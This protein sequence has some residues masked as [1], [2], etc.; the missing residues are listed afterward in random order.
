MPGALGTALAT[1]TVKAQVEASVGIHLHVCH[2]L[3]AEALHKV[4][5]DPFQVTRE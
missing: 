4:Y 5:D 2:V 1:Q 3:L